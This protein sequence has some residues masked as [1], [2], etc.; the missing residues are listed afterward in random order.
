MDFLFIFYA[1]LAERVCKGQ[2]R[3]EREV[4]RSRVDLQAFVLDSGSRQ[5]A[6]AW[7]VIS[8]NVGELSLRIA[9]RNAKGSL[10]DIVPLA[11]ELCDRLLETRLANLPEGSATTC[12]KGCSACCSYLVPISICEA[13]RINQD[14]NNLPVPQ[15][16][17]LE[18]TTMSAAR[19]IMDCPPPADGDIEDVSRWY[20]SL[21]LPCPMLQNHLCQIYDARPLA[22]REYVVD[23]PA[24]LCEIESPDSPLEL[25]V[26][27]SQALGALASQLE[28]SPLEAVMLPLWLAWRY[29]NEARANRH[30]PMMDMVKMLINILAQTPEKISAAEKAQPARA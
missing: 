19:T 8:A 3:T 29:D 27:V 2:V 18:R 24:G 15:R 16:L 9:V 17:H 4:R 14:L 1:R 23:K 30:W 26:S 6:G 12:R 5:L 7:R 22:C 11:R 21:E 10:A 20:R 25:A 13:L 28:Q